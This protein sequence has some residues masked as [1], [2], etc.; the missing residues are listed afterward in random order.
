MIDWALASPSI[1]GR[2][3]LDGRGL[4]V[5]LGPELLGH[6]LDLLGF[7]LALGTDLGDH[8]LGLR[9]RSLLLEDHLG[10]GLGQVGLGLGRQLLLLARL[11][12][13]VGDLGLLDRL[14]DQLG[15][16]DVPRQPEEQRQVLRRQHP[17]ELGGGLVLELLAGVAHQQVDCASPR[18]VQPAD[19]LDLRQ[20]HLVLDVLE[21]AELANDVGRLLGKNSPDR[22][23]VEVNR[24]AVVRGE[25]D[26]LARHVDRIVGRHVP[27]RS[28]LMA[29]PA[30]V[31][32][33]VAA[34]A[35]PPSRFWASTVRLVS[36]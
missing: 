27:S 34:V 15:H 29:R 25:L 1:S 24:K 11:G 30:S 35:L 22:R 21:R 12:Q 18:S 14:A 19:R 16:V 36:E 28:P 4:G 23:V 2:L 26:P 32:A 6:R 9:L 3:G 8:L 13:L 17:L 10:L 31:T 7:L 33:A 5:D 20:D